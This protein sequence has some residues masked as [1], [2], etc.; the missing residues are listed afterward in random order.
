MTFSLS[1]FPVNIVVI[2][3]ITI[4]S[5]NVVI[6]R[7]YFVKQV[8]G[9]FTITMPFGYLIYQRLGTFAISQ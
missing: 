5:S 8:V 7:S 9:D 1:E 2:G 3:P 6:H 4:A